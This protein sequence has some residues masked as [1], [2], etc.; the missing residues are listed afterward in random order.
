MGRMIRNLKTS[1]EKG[2]KEAGIG[3]K[4]MTRQ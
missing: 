4:R 3:G 1:I 2:W